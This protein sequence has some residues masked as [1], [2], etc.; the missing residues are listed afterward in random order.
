GCPN[1]RRYRKR[2]P[3]AIAHAYLDFARAN[4]VVYDAMF[5]RATTLR[6]AALPAGSPRARDRHLKFTKTKTTVVWRF[7]GFLEQHQDLALPVGTLKRQ[8]GKLDIDA[9]EALEKSS[10]RC[11]PVKAA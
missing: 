11:T 4:P 9:P 7:S 8:R 2:R 5:T 1:T 3:G 6:F 10:L